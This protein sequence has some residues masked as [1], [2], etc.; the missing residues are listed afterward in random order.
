MRQCLRQLKIVLVVAVLS[1]LVV[2]SAFAQEPCS[3]CGPGEHWVDNCS[4]GQDV[5]DSHAA[6]IGM[7]TNGDCIEDVSLVLHPCPGITPLTIT[8]S[9]PQDDSVNFPGLR[10][11]VMA[12]A[13]GFGGTSA[14]SRSAS[15]STA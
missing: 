1:G 15:P 2:C 7:D 11:V 12:R 13:R 8:R 3:E 6:V 4:S 14:F 9:D 5:V 10:P